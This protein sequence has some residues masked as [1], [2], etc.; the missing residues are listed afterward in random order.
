VKLCASVPERRE[1][2]EAGHVIEVQMG[3]EKVDR[4]AR[5]VREPQAELP[6]PGAGIENEGAAVIEAEL[7]AGG[8]A[9]V[10]ESR[11]AWRGEGAAAAPDR[12]NHL[13]SLVGAAVCGYSRSQTRAL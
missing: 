10:R 5:S 3:Q 12:R 1:E 8:V 13:S 11:R 6:D 9:A 7:D 2:G 4:R